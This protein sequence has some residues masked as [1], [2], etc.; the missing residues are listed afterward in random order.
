MLTADKLNAGYGNVHFGVKANGEIVGMIDDGQSSFDIQGRRFQIAR[1]GLLEVRLTLKAGDLEIVTATQQPLRNYY[2]LTSGRK[3]LTYK[4]TNTMATK[5][6]LFEGEKQTGTV[7]SGFWLNRTKGIMADFPDELP[8]E[9]QM[10]LLAIFIS[11]L[12]AD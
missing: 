7:S 10:F 1:T 5:Y 9:V 4:A 11:A 6:G 8:R 2:S 3:E 12:T